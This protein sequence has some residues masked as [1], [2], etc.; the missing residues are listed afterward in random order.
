MVPT[1][2]LW[3][4]IVAAAL[5][6][7]AI[8][9]VR[10]EYTLF[11]YA[12]AL[13]F[14]DFALPLGATVNL[15][16]DDVLLSVL[17]ARII[18]WRPAPVSR[19]QKTTFLWQSIFLGV[20]VVSLAVEM[21]QGSPPLAYDAARMTGCAAI[22]GVLPRVAQS[23]KRLRYFAAG[24]MCAGV[25][26]AIQV[27]MHLGGNGTAAANFQQLKSA[28]TF[29]TWNPNT[30]GQAAI[31]LVFGAGL[32]WIT[33]NAI[34]WTRV[35]WFGLAAGFALLPAAV[36]VRASSVSIAAGFLLFLVLLRRWKMLLLFTAICLLAILVLK[37]MDGQ[38]VQSATAVNITTGEG[39][40]DRFSRWEMALQAIR[41]KPF[42][43]HGFGQEL[44]YLTRIGSEGVSH[45]DYLTVW[46]ELGFGGLLIFLFMIVQFMRIGW[47]LYA[48]RP[49]RRQGALILATI[50][51]LV[52]DSFVVPT[53]YWEKLPTIALAIIA[54]LAGFCEAED[55]ESSVS[56]TRA[57]A[58][59]QA[60][61]LSS[62]LI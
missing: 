39:L 61:E 53:L 58:A 62:A 18:L 57:A 4:E 17:L 40:S 44:C 1:P 23:Q 13:G 36:F 20:C 22:L 11:L 15:R 32:G 29:D 28:A 37:K 7:L 46:L 8:L 45:N 31:L 19:S 33:S 51:A 35:I 5:L 54:A 59:S 48:T 49:F 56:E 43:G 60:E 47:R 24:L 41:Q 30:I 14:P 10:A 50:T 26:L 2:T 3:F 25:A 21:A 52:L 6:C 9:W 55:F 42:T 16:A 27:H 38:F 12:L 34:A